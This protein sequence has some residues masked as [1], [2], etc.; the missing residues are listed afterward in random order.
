MSDLIHYVIGV[1]NVAINR[2]SAVGTGPLQREKEAEAWHLV[3]P[4]P[5]LLPLLLKSPEERVLELLTVLGGG[6]G[7]VLIAEVVQ[8]RV[9]IVIPL[10][11]AMLA[12]LQEGLQS[13]LQ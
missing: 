7:L 8:A 10:V 1:G 13:L 9:V 4:R 6:R 2:Q 3:P 11:E 12:L 5:A